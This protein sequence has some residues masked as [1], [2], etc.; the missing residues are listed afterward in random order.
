MT[1]Q[2]KKLA[3]CARKFRGH[4]AKSFRRLVAACAR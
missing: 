2:Q 3:A 4:S 1:K